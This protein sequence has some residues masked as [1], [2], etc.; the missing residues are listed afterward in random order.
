MARKPS[1]KKQL[2]AL[3]DNLIPDVRKAFI[4]SI[5][6]V[7]ETAMLGAI[8]DAIREG[9]LEKA[10][11]A[12]GLSP[13]AM[14]PV[15][16]M[17]ESAFEKGGVTVSN[18]LPN[19]NSSAGPTIFRFD[20]R[21]S[22]AEA[23]LRDQ[24]S[25]LVTRIT[26]QTRTNIQTIVQ[27]GM[28]D[29]RNPRNVALDIIG[30]VDPATGRRTGGIVGLTDAQ[31][32]W[33]ANA[34]RELSGVPDAAYFT[35]ERRD[36]RFDKIVQRAI[37]DGKP[38]DAGKV[39]ALIGKYSDNLLQ[40]RGET[41][42]RTEML[43]ALA[44]SQ[45]EAIR[46]A[47]DTGTVNPQHVT[48][49]WDATGD[50]RTRASHA[51][52][53]G[54]SV[55]MDEAFTTPDGAKLL[56][57]GDSSLGAPASEIINCRCRVDYD[58]DFL[59]GLENEFTPAPPPAPPVPPAPPAP[60][61]APTPQLPPVPRL[62]DPEQTPEPG[63]AYENFTPLK[64]VPE[65]VQWMKANIADAVELTKGAD[66]DGLNAIA[67]ATLEVSERFDL[68]KVKF[69]GDPTK[70]TRAKWRFPARAQAAYGAS[71]DGFLFKNLA[72]D[73]AKL[74]EAGVYGNSPAYGAKELEIAR[75]VIEQSKFIDP[76]VRERIKRRD[77][78]QWGVSTGSRNVTYHEMGHRFDA[79]NFQELKM[80]SPSKMS[81]W[82]YLIGKYAYTNAAEYI[83]EAF[84]LYM[85][86][87]EAEYYRIYPPMLKFFKEK[88]RKNAR[89]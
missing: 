46:Q 85:Q 11:R 50:K 19:I 86:G 84:S 61:P 72:T 23:W 53:D 63:F 78:L 30:R 34:R 26:E 88:D 58:I 45:D 42:A 67:Q 59:A 17:I 25:G 18:A 83:A 73:N 2:E 32:K 69:I 6:D 89:N 82:H 39:D 35:R 80:R 27:A 87:N 66:L 22:R 79:F 49:K 47:I 37:N 5:R 33:V 77:G 28:R 44:K 71:L 57:P 4:A 38:L 60:R 21:N 16:S 20:V 76:E 7:S 62:P 8:I 15:T 51:A 29:G 65:A 68:P 31:A 14:R 24:S 40:L 36:R 41:I 52:M 10:F 56:I 1:L 12:T 75:K 13:A 3:A 43:Q 70:D 64:S 9:D 48:K 54:Q 74:L 81:G 55:K